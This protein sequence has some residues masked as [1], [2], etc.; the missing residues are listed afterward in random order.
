MNVKNIGGLI[1]T[2]K[3]TKWYENQ[4]ETTKAWLDAQAKEDRKLIYLG[5]IPGFILGFLAG[6]AILL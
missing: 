4:N 2:N 3:Y 1:L 6:A 5:M